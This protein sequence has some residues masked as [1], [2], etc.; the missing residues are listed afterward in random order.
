MGHA[1]QLYESIVP[2]GSAYMTNVK[3]G[4]MVMAGIDDKETMA[5]FSGTVQQKYPKPS[6]PVPPEENDGRVAFLEQCLRGDKDAIA[7]ANFIFRPE[8]PDERNELAIV[9][10]GQMFVTSDFIPYFTYE[11]DAVPGNFIAMQS[12]LLPYGTP[13][14]DVGKPFKKYTEETLT[15]MYQN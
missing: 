1:A 4:E 8:E 2:M 11:K 15:F 14:L 12:G 3:C 9:L 7:K 5:F 10:G 13:D 6:V